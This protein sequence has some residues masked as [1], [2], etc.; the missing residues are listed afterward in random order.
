MILVLKWKLATEKI[1]D[2]LAVCS[3]QQKFRPFQ[4][5]IRAIQLLPPGQLFTT[6]VCTA[7]L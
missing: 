2:Q 7:G 5:A 3:G 6:G 4:H 1:P